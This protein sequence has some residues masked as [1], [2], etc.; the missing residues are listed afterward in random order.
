MEQTIT[1]DVRDSPILE[2]LAAK[3]NRFVKS[4]GLRPRPCANILW[5]VA[6]LRDAAPKFRDLQPFLIENYEFTALEMDTHQISNTLW[7]CAKLGMGD[8]ELH[9]LAPLL[10]ERIVDKLDGFNAQVVSDVMWAIATLREKVPAL[11]SVLPVLAEVIEE[12]VEDF[13]PQEISSVLVVDWCS[14]RWGARAA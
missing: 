6:T 12:G 2:A 13:K 14:Q 1:L 9:S 7:A 3:V 4:S 11:Q 10:E 5:A 8:A